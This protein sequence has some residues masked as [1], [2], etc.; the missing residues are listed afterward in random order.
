MRT[1]PPRSL[2]LTAS[3]LL[4]TNIYAKD[5]SVKIT[6]EIDAVEI[7]HRGKSLTVERIQDE[8]NTIQ[9]KF[10]LTSRVCPP[11]CIQPVK[12]AD[13]VETIDELDMLDYL[14]R[15]SEG[16]DSILIID[17]RGKAWLDRGMI[18]GSI[19]IHYKA[20]SLKHSSEE[21]LAEILEEKFDVQRTN[22]FWDFRWAKTLVFYCNGMWCGQSPTSIKYLLRI[23]YP[24]SKLKWYRGGMQSWEILGLTSVKPE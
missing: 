10:Q 7:Q 18:P 19:N 9:P 3:L 13:D 8:K 12:L 23:G 16:D 11:F 14:K 2:A 1:H 20:L 5:P 15:M 22:E 4:A 6:P 24:P 17:S 21:D